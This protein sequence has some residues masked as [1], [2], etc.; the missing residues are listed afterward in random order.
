M[1]ALSGLITLGGVNASVAAAAPG[2]IAQRSPT[3]VTA[4]ALPTVQIDGVVWDQEIIGDTVYAGGEFTN[5]RPAGAAPGTNLSPRANLLSYNIRTGVLITSFAPTVNGKIKTLVASPDRKRLYIGGSFTSV[6]GQNR[7]RIA[8]FDVATGALTSFAPNPNSTV[9]AIA[10][11]DTVVYA[12]GAFTR[13]GAVD[14]SR[15]AAFS[16]VNGALLGWSPTS[17]ASVNALL[18]SPD[19]SRLIVAGAFATINGSPATG[20]AAVGIAAGEL[21]RWEANEVV[22]NYGSSSAMLSL[23]TDGTTVYSAGYWF[24]GVGNFEGLLAAD[25]NTGKIKWLADCHGDTYD[26]GAVNGTVYAVSHHHY[27]ANI[28]GFPDTNPRNAW[29]RANAFTTEATGTV[30]HDGQGYYDYFGQPAPSIV[31]WF[32]DVASGRFTGQNQ[33]GWT[34]TGNSEYVVQGGEFPTVNGTPQQGIVRFAIPALAPKK[35]GPRVA[36]AAFNPALLAVN[37]TTLRVKWQANWDRDDQN[38]RYQVF[39]SDKG[40]VPVYVADQTSQFWSRPGMSYTD[41]SVLAGQTY[42]YRVSAT[43]P[44]G[45]VV[46][47]ENVSVTM[48]TADSAYASQVMADGATDYWRMSGTGRTYGNY[49][50]QNDL[51]STTTGVTASTAGAL[52]GESEGAATYNGST[53]AS[54]TA[55][56]VPGP[57]T[58]TSEAWFKTTTTSGGKILG[59]GNAPTGMSGGYDR[60]VYMDNAGRL[61]FG[62]Y[63]GTVNTIRSA[64]PVNDGQWHHVAAS[65]SSAGMVMYVDGVK[66]G[67]RA[68][69]TTGQAYSGYWRV[70]ADNLNAWS[71][72][73]SSSYFNGTID[74]VAIYPTALSPAQLRNHYTKSG[75]TVAGPVA[76]ADNYG[77]AVSADDPTFFWRLNETSG[78]TAQDTTSNAENGVFAGGLTYGT[79]SNVSGA[80]GTAVTFNGS[81]AT[82]GSTT[83]VAAPSTY[84]EELWFKTTTARGGKLIGF[85]SSQSGSSGSFDRHVYMENSGQLTFGVWTGQTNTTTTTTSYND[86][87]WHHLVAMQSSDGMKLYVNGALTGT[88]PQPQAQGYS[89]HWRVGGDNS[90]GGDPFFAGSIDEVAVYSSALTSAQVRAHYLASPAAGDTL[91]ANSAPVAAF[92]SSCDGD[93]CTFD[94]S[95]STDPDGTVASYAWD[96]GDGKTATGATASHS[97]QTSGTKTVTLTVTDD[98]RAD[99]S[100]QHDVTVTVTAA[101][102]PPVA[103][104]TSSCVELVC[105]FDGS[106]STDADG[107]LTTYAWEFG[108]GEVSTDSKPSHTYAAAGTY[109]VKLTV[110]DDGGATDTVT[111][112]ATVTAGANE[113]PTAAFSSSIDGL[114]ARLD[115]TGSSDS[116]GTISTYAWD[117]GD[118]STG[119]A[120][121]PSHTYRGTGTYAVKLTVTDDDGSTTSLTKSIVVAPAALAQD[122][123]DR[124]VTRW[125]TADKGGAWSLSGSTYS[126]NGSTGNIRLAAAGAGATATLAGVSARNVDMVAD[127]VIDTPATGSGSYTTLISRKVG[128][129]DYRMSF[130]EMPGGAVR[131]GLARTVNGTTT[132]LRDVNLTGF[133]YNT[134]DRVRVRFQ[135]SGNGSTSLSGRVWKIGTPEPAS[136]QITATDSTV[137]LQA[138]GSV[139]LFTYLGGTVT[140]VPVTVKVDN[141]LVTTS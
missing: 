120:S 3:A 43:D 58:F 57:N 135:V 4:D 8:S 114:T 119:T 6:N 108:D 76:P 72:Q 77:K 54:A 122:S 97:Y 60:H 96:F 95:G 80:S 45:N 14:R 15:L 112:S 130:R 90:W 126:T 141:F 71:D 92:T 81:D 99:H 51:V 89:G 47:S 5:A 127:V 2:P 121:T 102:T 70:G 94:A 140:T 109:P 74:E 85:G 10:V 134:G 86:G 133:T 79:T 84:S 29:Y 73:P 132:S 107:T 41:K 118:G 12:G 11:S 106:T 9:S 66:V 61:N 124:T 55:V 1:G 48:P 22:H 25:P 110:T 100:V 36:G 116:D 7:Y 64:A 37:T 13:V 137:A 39:R 26:G 115:A 105:S 21:F 17:N 117:F 87:R 44:D 46:Q 83:P 32:P 34:T 139:A 75:R 131:L 38:L 88:N 16:P 50:G 128:T 59:L 20:L 129:S 67:S 78:G 82:I 98:K 33:G 136:A 18:V 68:S 101:N 56:A 40:T 138:S 35:Q 123:F 125:G 69:V 111:K 23:S 65:L 31:N 27:C 19:K 24:G 28:G 49:V 42:R 53:G 52:I 104:L 93:T 113:A 30:A 62:V 91:P 63:N 103:A